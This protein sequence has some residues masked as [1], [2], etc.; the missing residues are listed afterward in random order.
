[1]KAAKLSVLGAFAMMALGCSMDRYPTQGHAGSVI[2]DAAVPWDGVAHLTLDART[3]AQT[4]E[5]F[6]A[7]V[8]WYAESFAAYDESSPIWNLA[9]RD[10]GLDILR[11]RNRYGRVDQGNGSDITAEATILTRATASLGHEPRILL[12]SWSP[13]GSLKASGKE[14]CSG[15]K[16]TCTLA[17]DSSGQFVYDKF[18]AYFANALNTYAAAGIHPTYLSIQNEP[19]FVP[20]G[21]EGCRFDATENPS[22]PGYDRALAAVH[23]A[24]ATVDN[25]PKLIGPECYSLASGSLD[26]YLTPQTRTLLYAGAHHLYQSDFWRVPDAYLPTMTQASQSA[27]LP[28]MQTEFDTA[29]DGNVTGAFETA[30][31]MHNA[32]AIEGAA[33]FLY[34]DLIWGG[35]AGCLI[36]LK[37]A[38]YTLRN[39]Y[40][41]MRHFARYTDPGFVRIAAQSSADAVR[42]TAYL[43]PNAT[44]LT[45]VMLNTGAIE[46]QIQWDGI[47]G[48]SSAWSEVYR[49]TFVSGDAGT[50]ELWNSLGNLE[51]NQP[52]RLPS[53][54]VATVVLHA[55]APDAD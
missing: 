8:A 17:K 26:E 52:L 40:Y 1:M 9:F 48:F 5:G 53:H 28:L 55:D 18:G 49:S 14:N 7:A 39:H 31:V 34:W 3:H 41:A 43:S 29:G 23:A 16:S 50:S 46:A 21:W 38:S 11:F 19:D 47:N 45:V 32:L 25:P 6:G 20:N 24:L 22:Y 36:A 4:L 30:W 44:Q 54:S 51:A 12:S 2:T 42:V 15:D 33:G 37:G 10:L 27:N 13:P 35:S